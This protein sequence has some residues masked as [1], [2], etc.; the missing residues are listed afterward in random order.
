MTEALADEAVP[1]ETAPSA[2][3]ARAVPTA[4]L[5]VFPRNERRDMFFMSDLSRSAYEA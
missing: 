5:D 4:T 3:V 2:E 1:T